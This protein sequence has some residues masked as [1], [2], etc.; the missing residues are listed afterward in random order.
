MSNA[1]SLVAGGCDQIS[2]TALH[3]L[4][5]RALTELLTVLCVFAIS[6][7]A[8]HPGV[9]GVQGSQVKY[10]VTCFSSEGAIETPEDK[11]NE[12]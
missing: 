10:R 5:N 4:E 12:H 6:G 8:S 3:I 2:C 9:P 1:R 7:G 11:V